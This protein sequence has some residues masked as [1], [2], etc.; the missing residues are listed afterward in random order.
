MGSSGG[1]EVI[2][3]RCVTEKNIWSN[4]SSSQKDLL[5]H[6]ELYEK[7]YSDYSVNKEIQVTFMDKDF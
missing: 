4:S 2:I 5:S 3:Y 1:A 7:N 6:T